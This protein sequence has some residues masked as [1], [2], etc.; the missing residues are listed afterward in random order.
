[1]EFKE[2]K[3][4]TPKEITE[5]GECVRAILIATATA[6]KDGW[7]PGQDIPVILASAFSG[8]MSAI[9]GC[10]NIPEEFSE[11]PVAAT[12]GAIIPM[13]EGVEQMIKSLKK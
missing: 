7:Q 12:L 11:A 5:V 13:S 4:Q 3:L 6:L 1:M 2:I 8:L 9:E 10:Q